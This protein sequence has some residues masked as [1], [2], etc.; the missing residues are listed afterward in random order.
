MQ[1][2]KPNRKLVPRPRVLEMLG[3]I[4]PSA[5]RNWML[6][7][8]FP[9]PLD[10]GKEDGRSSKISWYEDEVEAW[11]AS[12]PRRKIGGLKEIQNRT[13]RDGKGKP[14]RRAAR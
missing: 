12:R 13:A 5:L 3:G 10:L 1:M 9:L 11:I 8:G 4:S 14:K 2:N 6:K 7:Q